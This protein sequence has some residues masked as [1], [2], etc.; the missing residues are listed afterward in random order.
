MEEQKIWDQYWSLKWDLDFDVY[1]AYSK[2]TDAELEKYTN[3][4]REALTANDTYCC[5]TLEDNI[6]SIFGDTGGDNTYAEKILLEMCNHGCW[7]E[8]D[9]CYDEERNA[10]SDCKKCVISIDYALRTKTCGRC[11]NCIPEDACGCDCLCIMKDIEVSQDD[12]INFYGEGFNEDC[13][14]FEPVE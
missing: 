10:W 14:D 8:K 2:L 11:K 12:D 1:H 4:L 6:I 3:E 7:I 13:K 9:F 5:V